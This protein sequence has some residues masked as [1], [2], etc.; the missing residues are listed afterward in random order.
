MK[1]ESPSIP[2]RGVSREEHIQQLVQRNTIRLSMAPPL[3]VVEVVSP[4]EL[5]R[6]RDYIAKRVQYQ[7]C[8]IPEYWIVAPEA[9]TVLVLELKENVYTE[10]GNFSEDNLIVSPGFPALNLK[11]AEIFNQ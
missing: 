3:L 5:Q 11:V 7:D 9:Q 10:I 4:G 1:E 6:N 8:G 2:K